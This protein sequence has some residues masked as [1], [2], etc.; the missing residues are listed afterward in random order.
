MRTSNFR[1]ARQALYI[2]DGSQAK[3]RP[4]AEPL[5]LRLGEGSAHLLHSPEG[6]R[7]GFSLSLGDPL[8]RLA[9]CKS[10][11]AAPG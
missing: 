3:Q 4:L 6:P 5:D 2:Q 7:S 8:C 1:Q 11:K 9:R 10:A